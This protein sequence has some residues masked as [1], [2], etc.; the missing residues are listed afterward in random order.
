MRTWL[1]TKISASIGFLLYAVQSFYF[2]KVKALYDQF[3]KTQDYET[4]NQASYMADVHEQIGYWASFCFLAALSLTM[5]WMCKR[6]KAPS[7]SNPS[8]DII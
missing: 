2:I 3:D 6:T 7:A 8:T 5:V 1:W 4:L